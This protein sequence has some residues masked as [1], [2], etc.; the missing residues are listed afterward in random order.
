MV[1]SFV[2]SPDKSYADLREIEYLAKIGDDLF[3]IEGTVRVYRGGRA[4]WR[5]PLWIWHDLGDGLFV[6]MIDPKTWIAEHADTASEAYEAW[7]DSLGS[8]FD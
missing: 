1:D 8:P 7:L 4:E 6:E 2:I 5:D 3:L